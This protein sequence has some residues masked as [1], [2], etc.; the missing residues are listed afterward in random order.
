M[1][2]VMADSFSDQFHALLELILS[3]SFWHLDCHFLLIDASVTDAVREV[4]NAYAI[5]STY[6]CYWLV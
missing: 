4:D 5:W 2:D 6:L 3:P 1:K